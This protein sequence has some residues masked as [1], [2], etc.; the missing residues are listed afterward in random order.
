[1][2]FAEM[3]V[4][5]CWA[6]TPPPSS[7]TLKNHQSANKNLAVV[8]ASIRS[9]QVAD[10]YLVRDADVAAGWKG[11]QA[12]HLGAVPK[13]DVEPRAEVRLVH[14]LSFPKGAATNDACDKASFPS[15]TYQSVAAIA[16]RID[17]CARRHPGVR[18]VLLKGDVKGWASVIGCSRLN[19]CTG[20]GSSFRNVMLY[21]TAPFEWA[22]S[23]PYYAAFGGPISWLVGRESPS[24][25]TNG[26]LTDNE[27]FFRQPSPF[28][29]N[30]DIITG[31]QRSSELQVNEAR[32]GVSAGK[33]SAHLHVAA[34][35]TTF[36]FNAKMDAKG[37]IERLK[38]RLV[39]C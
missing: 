5:P 1:M 36:L 12:S 21:M 33:P 11:I 35:N 25:L 7:T 30:G 20:W 32:S 14:D 22:G 28:S 29:C 34:C 24:T 23:P 27:P 31:T 9:G 6:A 18:I 26:K 38:A 19:Q 16:R 2:S 39:A 10:R 17:D 13:K 3:G 37:F 4:S 8:I 15:A